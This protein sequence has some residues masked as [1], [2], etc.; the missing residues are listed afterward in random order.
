MELL[1]NVTRYLSD[2]GLLLTTAESCTAGLIVSELARVPGSGQCID[3]GWTVYSPQAK[4]RYLAV[5][6]ETMETYGLTSEQTSRAMAL[7][8]LANED[9]DLAIANTG[10][11][12]PES[13]EGVPVGT[14]CFAWGFRHA[15][16]IYMFAETR[17]FAG[18]RNEVRLA[19][20]HYALER[21][22]PL[23]AAVLE[24]KAPP[25]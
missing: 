18:E 23:H 11:A 7:G 22:P 15:G 9:A 1:E 17:R 21:I 19:A 24:G 2:H 16:T 25:L 13:R 8:A 10:I 3:C 12:G 6:F 5:S 4:H 20:A 14:L